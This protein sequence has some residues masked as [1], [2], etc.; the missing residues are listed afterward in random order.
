MDREEL[1]VKAVT[2]LAQI[3]NKLTDDVIRMAKEIKY[4]RKQLNDSRTE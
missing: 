2:D 1:M 4:I 3:V